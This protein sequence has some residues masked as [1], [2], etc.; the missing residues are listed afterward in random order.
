MPLITF[1]LAL[2]VYLLTIA[3]DLTWAHFGVDGGELIAAATT[4]GVPHPPGYPTY[5]LLGKLF[6]LLP[7]GTIPLRFNLFS[8]VSM[9]I[10]AAFVTAISRSAC[11]PVS[12]SAGQSSV[13]SPSIIAGLTFAFA[14]LV[15]GQAVIT[16]VYALNLACLALFLWLLL[17]GR[18]AW[19]VGIALGVSMTTHLSSGL[20]LPLALW[21]VGRGRVLNLLT[22]CLLGLTPFLLIP[23]FAQNP[24]PVVWGDPTTLA[25][26][27]WVI[28]GRLFAGNVF[29]L[30]LAQWPERLVEWGAIPFIQFTPLGLPLLVYGL[31]RARENEA[32]ERMAADD[33]S[34]LLPVAPPLRPMQ[35]ALLFSTL[36]YFFYAF[37]YTSIDAI[38]FLLPGLLLL[39]VLLT[40]GLKR[41]GKWGWVLPLTLVALNFGPVNLHNEVGPRPQ[42]EQLLA[43]LPPNA[44][45]LSPGDET[46]FTLWALQQGE[47]IRPDLILVDANLFALKAYRQRL[48]QLFPHLTALT[49]DNLAAFQQANQQQPFCSVT[50]H[51]PQTPLC[52][53]MNLE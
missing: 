28:T 10:A 45:V 32:T 9:A 2:G 34:E 48:S 6:S 15:W 7:L 5:V 20:M 25:G 47:G 53:G 33:L 17:T 49:E 37:T 35:G 43:A 42:A 46:I 13:L 40:F 44:I 19:W 39:S 38:I 22:G 4:L 14:Q 31:Y 23:L 12:L 8:A 18:P 11:Q 29:A 52:Y 36:A 41:L 21:G 27:L 3:P 16:E 1:L 30:P 26:W 51:Q 50:I 24:T